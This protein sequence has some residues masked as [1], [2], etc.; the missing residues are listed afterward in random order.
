MAAVHQLG[1][2]YEGQVD[3]IDGK[4]I[5]SLAVD[6]S[7]VSLMFEFEITSADLSRLRECPALLT[8]LTDTLTPIIQNTFGP[9]VPKDRV[10]RYRQDEFNLVRDQILYGR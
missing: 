9:N 10:R 1:S 8:S 7:F 2:P 5:Y 4:F 3:E 6:S